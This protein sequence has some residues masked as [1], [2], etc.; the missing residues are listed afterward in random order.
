MATLALAAWVRLRGGVGPGMLRLLALLTTFWVV[1]RYA[2]VTASAVFGRQINLYWDGRHLFE[3]LAIGNVS[4]VQIALGAVAVVAMVVALYRLAQGC[5]SSIA[6]QL[7][8]RQP[9]PLL[10]LVG[11]GLLAAF[12]LQGVGGRNTRWF[13]SMPVA[14]IVARQAELIAGQLA[15]GRS[16]RQLS[17]S[18]AFDG[19]LAGLAGADVL[20]L[21]AESYGVSTL[22]DTAQA[23]AREP[24]RRPGLA[25]RGLDAGPAKAVARGPLLRLRP[26]GRRR[27][28]RL[29][30]P[31]LRPLAHS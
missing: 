11:L 8:W 2:E 27:H 13:F 22:D 7:A 3:V 9:L 30:R 5:W 6:R 20:L 19:T 24:L 10:V 17:P 31:G 25:H 12:M 16:D 28:H 4:R 15:P 14:P 1:T 23:H 29:C 18:P 26:R 21:F